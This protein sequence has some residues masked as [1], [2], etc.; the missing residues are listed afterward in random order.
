MGAPA[1]L[2]AVARG[3]SRS[4]RDAA[5]GGHVKAPGDHARLSMLPAFVV[6]EV[7]LTSHMGARLD[8][9]LLSSFLYWSALPANG[10]PRA[11]PYASGETVDL[12]GGEFV[13]SLQSVA[14]D[15]WDRF[16]GRSLP[17]DPQDSKPFRRF[18]AL[19][20]TA[21]RRLQDRGWLV[22]RG[23][24]VPDKGALLGT[25]W[26]LEGTPLEGYDSRPLRP[27]PLLEFGRAWPEDGPWQ[28]AVDRLGAAFRLSECEKGRMRYTE[29]CAVLASRQREDHPT[30]AD[31]VENLL[32]T[33]RGV[34]GERHQRVGAWA[35]GR[36]CDKGAPVRVPWLV[37]E[38]DDGDFTTGHIT[39]RALL[40][41]L[42]DEYDVEGAFE[43]HSGNRSPHVRVPC[44]AW[45]D[46][47]FRDSKTAHRVLVRWAARLCEGAGVAP[48]AVDPGPLNPLSTIRLPG[49]TRRIDRGAWIPASEQGR[50]RRAGRPE[51]EWQQTDYRQPSRAGEEPAYWIPR[52]ETA[53]VTALPADVALQCEDE[54][55]WHAA[56][57][58]YEAEHGP[59]VPG[60]PEAAPLSPALAL[61]LMAAADAAFGPPDWI[62]PD[63]TI[64]W[65]RVPAA[66]PGGDGSAWSEMCER[67]L[68]DGHARGQTVECADGRSFMGRRNVAFFLAGHLHR[69]HGE[70][71]WDRLVAWNEA[72]MAP[73]LRAHELRAQWRSAADPS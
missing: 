12:A 66:R 32:A 72:K 5:Q 37:L 19:V 69:L 58:A 28:N 31:A 51:A 53:R 22:S 14:E 54:A 61:S 8:L 64:L 70:D 59:Y 62:G 36:E 18:Y 44:G 48:E 56:V 10:R 57:Y 16:F 68:A 23:P 6:R 41:H 17:D 67:V 7:G 29:V 3:R 43:A 25:V 24:A 49:S 34:R 42:Q 40:E 2:A 52:W 55:D 27:A 30:F 65:E 15:L 21:A 4:F 11:L 60:R 73:P 39:A 20:K 63:G 35:R 38:V 46:V 45:G 50:R 71:G 26:T 33:A 1:W 47:A 9:A 13:L